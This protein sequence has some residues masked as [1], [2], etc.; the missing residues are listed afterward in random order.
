MERVFQ[1]VDDS[2]D[3]PVQS[4]SRLALELCLP[5]AKTDA[6]RAKRLIA[7]LNTPR[8]QACGWALLALGLADRD[9][10]GARSALAESIRLIDQL[11]GPP[12]PAERLTAI[13][14]NPAASILPIVEQLAPERLEELFWKAIALIPRNDAARER[15]VVDAQ[16]ANATN[17]LARYDRQ[18]ADM[19]LNQAIAS[20]SRGVVGNIRSVLPVI[21]AKAVADPWGAVGLFEIAASRPGRARSGPFAQQADG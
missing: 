6:E 19:F 10:A 5:V 13:T 15:G 14:A 18:A 21:R 8:E 12:G 1:L 20:E 7:V 4:K 9:K 2:S 16:V 11:D 3:R 17:F